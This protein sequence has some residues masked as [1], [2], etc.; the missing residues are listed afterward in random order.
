MKYKCNICEEEFENQVEFAKHILQC[1]EQRKKAEEEKF[2]AK[3]QEQQEKEREEIEKAYRAFEESVNQYM[4]KYGTLELKDKKGTKLTISQSRTDN[5]T[6]S[7]YSY[8]FFTSF[9]PINLW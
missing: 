6:Y 8:P 1:E 3:R 2:K 4:L 5:S 9:L 7:Y